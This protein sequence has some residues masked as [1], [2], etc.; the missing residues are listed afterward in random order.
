MTGISNRAIASRL[1]ISSNT[2]NKHVASIL[3]KLQARSRSQAIAIVLGLE[4]IH[5]QRQSGPS[6]PE[7][8]IPVR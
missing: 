3:D 1:S 5:W 2:V 7:V 8:R 6:L 4:L